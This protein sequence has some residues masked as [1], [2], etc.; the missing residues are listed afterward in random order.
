MIQLKSKRAAL[1]AEN[2]ELK[3][4]LENANARE[5]ELNKQIEHLRT[6]IKENQDII[7]SSYDVKAGEYILVPS[8]K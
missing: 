3:V 1:E 2:I 7:S 8:D 4:S 5:G 6:E